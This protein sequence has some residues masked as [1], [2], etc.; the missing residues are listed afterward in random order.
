MFTFHIEFC[1][2]NWREIILQVGKKNAF[3]IGKL[4]E[5]LMFLALSRVLEYKLSQFNIPTFGIWIKIC[6]SSKNLQLKCDR[7]F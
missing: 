1:V 6:F 2:T 5:F 4:L 7:S 3:Q